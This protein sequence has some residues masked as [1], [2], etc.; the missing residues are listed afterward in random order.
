MAA[1]VLAAFQAEIR[2]LMG[3]ED[4]DHREIDPPGVKAM[5]PDINRNGRIDPDW[6]PTCPLGKL[7]SVTLARA[8]HSE[9]RDVR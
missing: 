8:R 3:G 4:Q 1:A 9:W 7:P 6:L 2:V 5:T